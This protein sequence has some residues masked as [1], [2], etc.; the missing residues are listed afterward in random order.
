MDD[1]VVE[2][3]KLMSITSVSTILTSPGRNYLLVVVKTDDGLVGY[4]DATLNGRERAVATVVEDSIR[5]L[6]V[7]EDE[8]RIEYL[9]RKIYLSAYWRGGPVL[10]T[11]LA[12]IDMALWDIK[13]KRAGLP[14]YSLLGG[15]ARDR[16][17]AYVHVHGQTTSQL[18]E[19]S[20]AKVDAGFEALR[21]SFDSVDPR[22]PS[23][24]YCQAHQDVAVGRIERTGGAARRD[25]WD[26]D[27]Y[28]TDLPRTAATLR[29]TLGPNVALIHDVHSRLSPPRAVRAAKELESTGLF[30]LEDPAE[31]LDLSTLETIRA[32]TSVPIAVGELY[33]H[34]SDIAELV[35][36][37]LVDYVRVDISHFGGITPVVKLAH[38]AEALG[39]R[40]AFHGP[41]DI[42]PPAHAA[43]AHLA[44]HLGNFG[45][46]EMVEDQSIWSEVFTTPIQLDRGFITVGNQP[47]LGV[48]V[49]EAAARRHEFVPASLPILHDRM[50]AIHPW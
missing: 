45:I 50:G 24:T 14:L 22:D 46:Q 43:L 35:R 37:Q 48:S 29:D 3:R 20:R 42:S 49:D 44:V 38:F 23:V 13:G 41:S 15:K 21:F 19:R 30:F 40:T 39:I 4:G 34:G 10:M 7:D 31:H 25:S 2:R 6:L 12:G 26:S 11:A 27:T 28:L 5:Q 1:R 8:S 36:R 9:W 32:Q 47:G 33:F 16:A 18:V 17:R